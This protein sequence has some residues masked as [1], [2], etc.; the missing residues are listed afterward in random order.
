MK[1]KSLN[2]ASVLIESRND[3][4]LVDPWLV[5]SLY[6]E[7]WS[8]S[9]KLKNSN[10]LKNIN[11]VFISHLHKDHWDSE[12]IKLLDP[13]T[14]FYIPNLNFNKIIISEL[15][16]MGFKNVFMKDISKWQDINES[17]SFYFVPP[18]NSGAQDEKFYKGH[19]N[20][21]PV[22]IDTGFIFKD[23]DTKTN[24]LILCD[25]SPYDIDF[26]L[27]HIS[28]IKIDSF[29]FPFNGY[30]GDFPLCYDN[31][32]LEEK[33]GFSYKMSRKRESFLIDLIY[34]IKPKAL[35]PHSSDF[36]LNGPRE[37]EFFKVHEEEFIYRNKYA[38]RIQKKTG[39]PSYALYE[40]DYIEC[41]NKNI[42][43]S[44]NH[45]KN[46]F[47]APEGRGLTFPQPESKFTIKD[48]LKV[49]FENMLSRAKKYNLPLQDTEDWNLIINLKKDF[50]KLSMLNKDVEK[51]SKTSLEK[52]E[53]KLI[54]KIEEKILRCLLEGKIRF[55]N[56][57]IGCYL[58]WERFP[59]NDFNI[60]LYGLLNFFYK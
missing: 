45:T 34:K 24:H 57:Q 8:P 54:L 9:V 32:T 11:K 60:H 44:I 43:I 48:D 58:N 18:L 42:K 31:F 52:L 6:Q 22:A 35:I 25:N 14:E 30:A 19:S 12:T 51:I 4:I 2:N 3:F 29:W 46:E 20:V 37:K 10:F 1:L 47:I 39:I 28:N 16:E 59:K 36:T 27:K 33:K 26:A 5:G 7:S 17:L 13:K 53:K 40:E 50:Y 21:S 55:D 56:A 15:H 49:A 38:E 23:K 41:A